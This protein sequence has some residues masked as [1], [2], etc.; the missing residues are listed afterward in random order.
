VSLF[1]LI[2]ILILTSDEDGKGR[3]QFLSGRGFSFGGPAPAS[4]LFDGG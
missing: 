1:Y 4:P 2:E 3:P